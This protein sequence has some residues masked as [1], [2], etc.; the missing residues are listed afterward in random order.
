MSGRLAPWLVSFVACG[1]L[2]SDARACVDDEQQ[3]CVDDYEITISSPSVLASKREELITYIWPASGFPTAASELVNSNVTSPIAGLDNLE[4]VEQLRTSMPR[5]DNYPVVV[6]TYHFIPNRKRERLA[7]VVQ[8]HGCPC[9]PD[10]LEDYF[11]D[12]TKRTVQTLLHDGYSVMTIFMPLVSIPLDS[13]EQC[14]NLHA[15]LFTMALPGSSGMAYFLEPTAKS[16]NY[17][18]QH[19]PSYRDFSMIGVSGGGWTTTVY[20]AIDTR[21]K[22]SIPVAA[23]CRFFCVRMSIRMTQN[24]STARSMRSRDIRTCTSLAATARSASRFR[25]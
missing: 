11:D 25:S 15:E 3:A 21:I 12:P 5:S 10:E 2:A 13:N 24:R 17:A 1:V 14:T 6:T 16:L 18:V 20:A 7:V 22:I 19:Y 9:E 23:R 4:R 8:G